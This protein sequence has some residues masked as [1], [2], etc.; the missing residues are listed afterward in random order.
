MNLDKIIPF[1]NFISPIALAILTAFYVYFAWKLVKFSNYANLQ[2]QL[3]VKQQ[4]RV[5]TAPYLRCAVF[6]LNDNVHFKLSNIGRGPAY[7]IELLVLG[8]YFES[9][10][11]IWQFSIKTAKAELI[12]PKVDNEGFFHI[13]DRI[14]YGYAFPENEV[15]APLA[16]PERPKSLSIL[17]QYK[18]I[19]GDNFCQIYWF[20]ESRVGP[21][22][23]YKLGACY[24]KVLSVSPR[25]E[26]VADPFRL[27]AE[28]GK[29]LPKDLE[30][31]Q[32]YYIF[33]KSLKVAISSGY[34]N[35]N[36][37]IE[38]RGEWKNI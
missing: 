10:H 24:P 3:A 36:L 18:D 2:N 33:N 14:I 23:F 35:P 7:D 22:S 30:E 38:D 34:F 15:E 1:V 4:I 20:F 29:E 19:S 26:F 6:Q 27:I 17:L 37:E 9:E 31:A 8:D 5:M 32:G 11:D 16:F 25:I 21:K 28:N 13:Y 12:I